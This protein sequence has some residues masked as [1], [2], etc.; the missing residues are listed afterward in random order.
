MKFNMGYYCLKFFS[1]M[2]CRESGKFS[3]WLSLSSGP[4]LLPFC[5]L[6]FFTQKLFTLIFL[7]PL[8]PSR[9]CYLY[10]L[11]SLHEYIYQFNSQMFSK[12]TEFTFEYQLYLAIQKHDLSL[13][14]LGR[15]FEIHFLLLLQYQF[16]RQVLLHPIICGLGVDWR[17]SG[18]YSCCRW[19]KMR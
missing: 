16:L 4:G 9:V 2:Y 12:L 17:W 18:S 19:G 14:T 15:R 1:T 11:T 10:F 3:H 7:S 5:L 13:R 6:S 8:P